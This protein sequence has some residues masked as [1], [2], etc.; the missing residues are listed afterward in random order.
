MLVRV[1]AGSRIHI[2]LA[3]MGR[4]SPRAY[5]GIG[6]MVDRVSGVLE[7]RQSDTPAL[8]AGTLDRQTHR[9]LLELVTTLVHGEKAAVSVTVREHAPQHVG[10]GTKTALK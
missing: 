4:A 9:E 7:I 3:D 8:Q 1:S 2:S 5:G 6:F 10:F